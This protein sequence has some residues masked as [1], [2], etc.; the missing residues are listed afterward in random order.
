MSGMATC[1]LYWTSRLVAACWPF[2]SAVT[3][4]RSDPETAKAHIKDGIDVITRATEAGD[5]E[6]PSDDMVTGHRKSLCRMHFSL[7][8]CQ[9]SVG[10][11]DMLFELLRR[12]RFSCAQVMI[13]LS[14]A[15]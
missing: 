3:H 11:L 7:L 5:N 4:A 8:E 15:S 2:C 12:S 13:C 9:V 6:Q 1:L 14:Q 10:L